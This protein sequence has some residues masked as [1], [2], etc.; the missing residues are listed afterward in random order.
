MR[1]F[2][3]TMLVGSLAWSA[4]AVEFWSPEEQVTNSSVWA[5]NGAEA[6][7]PNGTLHMLTCDCR[8]GIPHIYYQRKP[9]NSA[10]WSAFAVLSLES[11]GTVVAGRSAICTDANQGVYAVWE[12]YYGGTASIY[13]RRSTD[14]GLTWSSRVKVGDTGSNLINAA[15][16]DVVVDLQGVLHL[17]WLQIGQTATAGQVM[18][19]KGS[20]DGST[21]SPAAALSGTQAAAFKLAV[22]GTAIFAAYQE[23]SGAFQQV[24][25]KI[26][27]DNGDSWGNAQ[28]LATS[29]ATNGFTPWIWA[30]SSDNLYATWTQGSGSVGTQVMFRYYDH[31]TGLANDVVIPTTSAGTCFSPRIVAQG[32]K[33]VAAW[34]NNNGGNLQTRMNVSSDLGLSWGASDGGFAAGNQASEPWLINDRGNVHLFYTYVDSQGNTAISGQVRHTLRD[35]LAPPAPQITSATHPSANASGNN[36][37][38]FSWNAP[39]NAGGI[40]IQG[41]ALLLDEQPTTDP[42]NMLVKSGQETTA[43]F[44]YVANGVHYFHLRAVDWLGNTGTAGHYA[45][46]VDNQSFFPGD[47]VWVAP[48]PVRNGRL[49]LHYFLTKTADVNVAFFDAAGRKIGS[50]NLGSNVGV[51]QQ[52]LDISDWVNGVYFYKFTV[53]ENAQGQVAR[54]TKSFAVV[55]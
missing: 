26:S 46:L 6:V 19:R 50:Q 17:A 15:Y 51:N 49:N 21:L 10:S 2:L 4:Y 5:H 30:D 40:G 27:R 11:S 35:D 47:Q 22:G 14:D 18:Y 44:A 41:Y 32:N 3:M 1:T 48:S 43:D 34:I 24:K 29:T 42:G 45:I 54:V 8:T 16:P 20:L 37:P 28:L 53:R 9:D 31:Q 55:K 23:T 7:G 39:D 52:S 36:H 33:T 25:F 13:F 38:V 12:E